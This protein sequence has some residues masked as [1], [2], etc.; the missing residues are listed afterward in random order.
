M[1]GRKIKFEFPDT[2]IS[3][4]LLD[5]SSKIRTSTTKSSEKGV[6]L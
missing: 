2:L 6:V 5:N 1:E 3:K 4:L